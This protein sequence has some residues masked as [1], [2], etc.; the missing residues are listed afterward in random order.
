M[1]SAPVLLL[2]A[3]LGAPQGEARPAAEGALVAEAERVGPG[4]VPVDLWNPARGTPAEPSF[5]GTLTVH[6]ESLPSVLNLALQNSALARAMLFELHAGLVQRDWESWE[7]VP[8]LATGWDVADTLVAKDGAVHRGHVRESE[9]KIGLF[10]L[11]PEEG[12]PAPDERAPPLLFEPADVARV[13]R[14]T[15]VTFHLRPDARWH[16]GHP[17][18]AGDVLFTWS[19]AANP[20]VR[21]D[22]IRPYLQKIEALEVLDAHTVRFLFREQYFNTLAL[23]V[24][25]FP[26]LPRH[27]FDLRDPDHAR[28]DERASPAACAREINENGHNTRWIGL[29][30]YRL[31]DY[32]QQGVEA[33]RF[34]GF[35]DPE[36]G[37]FV[38]RIRWRH[39]ANDQA[40][41]SALLNGELDFTLRLSSEQYFGAATRQEAFERRYCKGYYYL[42]AFNYVPWNLRRP[43]L[44][45]LRVRKG[46][47]HAMDMEAFVQSVAHGLAKLPTGPQ[48]YFGPSYDH[49][50]RRLAFDPERA[51]ELFAEAGWY[52]RDG[53]GLMDRDGQPFSIEMMVQSGNTS[54]EVFARM[55]QESLARI[56]ARL[57]I[58]PVD[59]ATYFKRLQERD[60][61]AGQG[62]WSVDVTEND[63]MQLWHSR[64]AVPGGSNH[65]GVVD[66]RVDALIERGARELDDEQRWAL[67][68]E[69]HRLL[70]EEIQPYLYR[71]APPRKF[72]LAKA[73]RGVQFFRISPGY[74]LRRWYYPAGTPGTRARR[75]RE[76]DGR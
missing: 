26:I 59:N 12:G 57:V 47:A 5:G 34:D 23:F 45:D 52:D 31:T 21:C 68:R 18:D 42:G 1:L 9:G 6:L 13:E 39:I 64:S 46:L 66:P 10:P 65:A 15:V 73:L 63:P 76:P 14:G 70:Y 40:A 67:W 71:E 53:D 22:W 11:A 49:S 43:L 38:D 33:E 69:L 44:S 30:P 62:G 17:F 35:F 2:A 51:R 3:V 7:L 60:F 50:V 36:H 16:D 54:A 74:A 61:D 48:C 55:L 20:D 37:G 41:F 32:A 25:D 19:I 27:L 8:E 29:G 75:E 4:P 56:G 58:T 24:D 72:A 28:H